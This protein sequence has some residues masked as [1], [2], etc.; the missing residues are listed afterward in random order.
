[1]ALDKGLRVYQPFTPETT[2]FGREGEMDEKRH[3]ELN[4]TVWSLPPGMEFIAEG[5]T[6]GGA[7]KPSTVTVTVEIQ[8]KISLWQAIKLR[9][10]GEA[11]KHVAEEV[12]H[13]VSM[14]DAVEADAKGEP[15]GRE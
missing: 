2:T 3:V 14:Y 6:K 12:L 1:M 4:G 5:A 7:M 10:A 9:I 13:R 15:C 11:Y 8:Y